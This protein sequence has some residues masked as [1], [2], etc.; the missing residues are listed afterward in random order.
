VLVFVSDVAFIEKSP[1]VVEVP[2]SR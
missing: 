1:Y 2:V